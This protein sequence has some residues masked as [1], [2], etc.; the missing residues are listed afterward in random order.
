MRCDANVCVCHF[1]NSMAKLEDEYLSL[2]ALV[3]KSLF[4]VVVDPIIAHCKKLLNEPLLMRKCRH[5]R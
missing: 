1:V 2:H 4:D 3:W 5:M